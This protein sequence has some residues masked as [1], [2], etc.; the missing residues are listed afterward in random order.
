MNYTFFITKGHPHILKKCIYEMS[1]SFITHDSDNY[2]YVV[3]ATLIQFL[4]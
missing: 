1:Y 2:K 4:L 3:M